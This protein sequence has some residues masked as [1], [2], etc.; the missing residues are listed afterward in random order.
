M[1]L[2]KSQLKTVISYITFFYSKINTSYKPLDEYGRCSICG[3]YSRFWYNEMFDNRSE[4]VISCKWD[5]QFTK[6]IN[7]TNSLHCRHCMAKFRVRVAARTMLKNILNGKIKSVKDLIKTLNEKKQN[8]TILET[9]ST[10]GIFS[11]YDSEYIIKSEFFDNIQNG[12][13]KDNIISQDLQNLTFS[14]NTF[15]CIIA[16]DVFEHIPDP[17]KAFAEIVRVLKTNGIGVITI[18][19]DDKIAKTQKLAEIKDNKIIYYTE[20][21]YH[22]DPLR[23]EG[24]L[25]YTNFAKDITEILKNNNYKAFLEKYYTKTREGYQYVLVIRK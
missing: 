12:K 10:D 6:L 15:D 2:F 23:K 21:S 3:K 18:P 5:T 17:T 16:L 7:L 20:P 1:I 8:L 9:A 14:D 13:I 4:V 22:S 24:A 25:V 11:K 19:I